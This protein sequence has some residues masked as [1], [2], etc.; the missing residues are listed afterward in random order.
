MPKRSKFILGLIMVLLG[1]LLMFMSSCSEEYTP[2]PKGYPRI[3]LPAK[4]YADYL[5]DCPFTFEYHAESVISQAKKD[6]PCW[7]NIDYPDLRARIHLSYRPIEGNLRELLEDSRTLVYK[8]TIKANAI[9]EENI[10]NDETKV[11]SKI[12]RIDGNAAS[13]VQFMSTDSS[14]H[15]LRGALY[16]SAASNADSLQ[17]AIDYIRQ[18]VNHLV[19]SVKWK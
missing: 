15:F 19:R 9:E 4:S 16:F 8:H 5:S 11:Y 17:P 1:L 7:L 18:D 14:E 2:K 6:Q 12:Y 3:D 13:S 10:I